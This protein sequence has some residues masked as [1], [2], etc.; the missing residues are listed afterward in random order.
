MAPRELPSSPSSRGRIPPPPPLKPPPLSMAVLTPTK[1]S[2][3]PLPFSPSPSKLSLPLPIIQQIIDYL[4]C[5]TL[6]TFA[7]TNHAMK[8]LVY[9]E[10]RWVT[11]LQE[12]GVWDEEEARIAAEE[13]N[14]A[15]RKREERITQEAV[16][17]RKLSLANTA[18]TPMPVTTTIF[19][20]SVEEEKTKFQKAIPNG[21]LLDFDVPTPDEGFGEFISVNG[22][23]NEEADQVDPL[24]VLSNVVPKMGYARKE[25]G[26]VYK[27]LAPLYMDLCQSASLDSAKA[28]RNRKQLEEQAQL[29]HI[30]ELF[31]RTDSVDDWTRCQKRI[32]WITETFERQTLTEFEEYP[33]NTAGLIVRAYDAKDVDGKMRR[34]AGILF[35][36]NGGDSCIK[37][38]IRKHP[39]IFNQ[40]ENPMTC[41]TYNPLIC[42]LS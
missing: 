9:E 12:M 8:D 36:L 26:K 41:L 6:L 34:Y 21:D 11:K 1:L 15:K 14:N 5:P 10:S 23:A 28:F 17:G 39:S 25:F 24:I 35:D 37:S 13:E 31:G 32:A 42:Q 20:A 4:P 30:F 2:P 33:P 40:K 19:D 3:P 38:F 7:R 22:A 16:L 27:C 18:L 29:L